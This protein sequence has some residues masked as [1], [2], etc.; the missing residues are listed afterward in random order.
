MHAAQRVVR[1]SLII[2]QNDGDSVDTGGIFSIIY[3]TKGSLIS[4]AGAPAAIEAEALPVL[5]S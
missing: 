5:S 3:P 4:F 2:L 1:I